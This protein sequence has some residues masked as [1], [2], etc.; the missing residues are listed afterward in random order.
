MLLGGGIVH[1]DGVLEANIRAAISQDPRSQ[2]LTP[3]QYDALI[4]ALVK[5]AQEQ[6]VA[7]LSYAPA[8]APQ[9][10]DAEVSACEGL[11]LLC[12]LA[13]FLGISLMHVWWLALGFLSGSIILLFA[14][15]HHHH[16][17]V[18]G[19]SKPTTYV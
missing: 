17:K 10:A 14:L 6:G 9:S 16:Q 2:S 7:S 1:A 4:Q 13:F 19:L 12:E 11:P 18:K 3:A 15:H 5:K 8:P